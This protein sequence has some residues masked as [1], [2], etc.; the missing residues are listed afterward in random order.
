MLILPLWH[1]GSYTCITFAKWLCMQTLLGLTVAGTVAA[2][3][4]S[5]E[6]RRTFRLHPVQGVAL[7]YLAWVLLS[8]CF[9]SFR[10]ALN[11][12]GLPAVWFGARRY[13][14]ALTQVGYVAIFLLA[15]LSPVKLRPVIKAAGAALLI[16]T[17]VTALQYAGLNPFGLFPTGRSVMT[18]YEFQGTLG[19]I[20][21]ISGWLCLI[22]PMLLGG[23]AA[24]LTG[25]WSLLL[26]G[27]GALL[28]LL[29]EVQSGLLVLAALW[30]VLLMW[31]LRSACCRG[32]CLQCMALVLLML[33]LRLMTGLPWLDGT[34]I[35]SLR[36]DLWRL[37]PAGVGLLMLLVAC[38]PGRW[39][40]SRRTIVVGAAL[41]CVLAVLAVY[42]LPMPGGTGLWEVQEI[43]HGRW[44]DGFG[45][46][47]LGV[48]RMTLD[49][50][51]E[52]LLFGIGPD[53]FLYALQQYLVRTGQSLWQT[54]DNPHQMLL[55]VLIG[56]G[57][58]ALLLY[59]LLMGW[60]FALAVRTARK[61]PWT[62]VLA[63]GAGG[64]LLQGMFVFSVCLVTPLFWLTLGMMV[65]LSTHDETAHDPTGTPDP[66]DS[67]AP[68]LT[69]ALAVAKIEEEMQ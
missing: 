2:L 12:T 40:L 56:S 38:F 28:V 69:P 1:S 27:V 29:M 25:W 7:A 57:V 43:L 65:S 46:E 19:N 62:G 22:G 5:R 8:A 21:I 54:F 15:S 44:Q 4:L 53:T 58:P 36:V 14:G 32:R 16:H 49:M 51:K 64:Y 59:L 26:G 68:Q 33:S 31:A 6:K 23:Y 30:C 47:R 37:L 35:V 3:I 17:G 52:K 55:A 48:W 20:D 63:L 45:S 10:D 66:D 67:T 18:N 13:E 24:R 61:N 9:G 42:V 60:V 11:A 41:A 50:S 34:E 39:V